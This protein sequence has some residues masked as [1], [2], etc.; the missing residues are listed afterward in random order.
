MNVYYII[1]VRKRIVIEIRFCIFQKLKK[2]NHRCTTKNHVLHRNANTLYNF[3]LISL[4]AA[5]PVANC[6]DGAIVMRSTLLVRFVTA[7]DDDGSYRICIE[8][9]LPGSRT[10]L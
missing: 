7:V 9:P 1:N 5:T 6:Q 8:F 2:Y 4:A 3:D 10:Y